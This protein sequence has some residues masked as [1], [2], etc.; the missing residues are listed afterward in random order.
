ML[1]IIDV[2]DNAP[3]FDKP[4]YEFILS[5]NMR[6]FTSPAFLRAT[7]ADA[8][9]PNNVIRYEIVDGNYQDK[10]R[11][12]K[13]SGKFSRARKRNPCDFN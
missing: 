10:F 8:E 11:V 13:M 4:L 12:D 2:N 7:D 6:N 9:G 1:R 3:L 5:P